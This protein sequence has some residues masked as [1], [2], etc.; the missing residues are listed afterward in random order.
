MAGSF[1]EIGKKLSKGLFISK[2]TE[3]KLIFLKYFHEFAYFENFFEF[4]GLDKAEK[5]KDRIKRKT[6]EGKN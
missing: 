4:L 3:D 6:E 5:L 1:S 2:F